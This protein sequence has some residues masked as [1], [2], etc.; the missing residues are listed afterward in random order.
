MCVS[1]LVCVCTLFAAAHSRVSS[2]LVCVLVC[3]FV[4]SSSQLSQLHHLRV[5][6]RV[7][8]CEC[9]CVRVRLDTQTDSLVS[10]V[11]GM[12]AYTWGL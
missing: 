2:I 4:C 6:V 11:L 12:R 7:C 10:R 5:Y 8:V 1:A 3:V 9:V